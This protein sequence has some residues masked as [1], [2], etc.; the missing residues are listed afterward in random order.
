MLKTPER[1]DLT[2]A[3]TFGFAAI[4]GR[5][6]DGKTVQVLI[7]NYEI[8]ADY[9]APEMEAPAGSAPANMP[10]PDFS[11][12]KALSPRKDIRY[13][14]NRGYE[15]MINN[16]PWGKEGSFTVKRYRLAEGQDFGVVD[17]TPASGDRI[18]IW[19]LLAPLPSS[20]S[21]SR[22]NK[23]VELLFVPDT[24]RREG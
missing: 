16:L 14:N 15:L 11:K 17:E 21:C 7:S 10:M 20:L 9:K 3:D 6:H 24:Q 4:A 12:I 5:S 18:K 22:D 8:P 19:N 1:L 2:G 13:R 23:W